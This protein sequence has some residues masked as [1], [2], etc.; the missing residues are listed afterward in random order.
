MKQT[1][2]IGIDVA[3]EV[4]VVCA[5]GNDGQVIM[6]TK[7]PTSVRALTAA[8][9]SVDRPRHVAFEEGCQGEWLH[10]TLYSVCDKLLVCKPL[11]GNKLSGKNKADEA[12]ACNLAKQLRLGALD[13][14]WHG[15][16][17]RR[18]K[19]LQLAG[20]YEA[21]TKDQ[22]RY[23]N[24]AHAV[25]RGEGVKCGN[26]LH[27]GWADKNVLKKLPLEEQKKRV[28]IYDEMI[29]ILNMHRGNVLEA[30]KQEAK[31]TSLYRRVMKAPQIG[32]VFAALLTAIIWVP[33]RFRNNRVFWSYCGLAV[34]V[35]ET[36]QYEI[37]DGSI[38][39]KKRQRTRG[40]SHEYNRT[41]KCIFKRGAILLASGKWKSEFERLQESG[42]SPEN[43]RLT[44]ARKLASITLHLAKTGESYDET[45]VFA[46]Q[47]TVV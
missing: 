13:A 40:R 43:A 42:V 7:V 38:E 33:E 30:L 37:K 19:L 24:R 26:G 5:I 20:T 9:N 4:S 2:Y 32:E 41:L 45:K 46:S 35:H 34:V 31:K 27:E 11:K 44:L 14:V 39:K 15:T 21:L 25:F 29:T 16:E 23:K 1:N 10:R 6:T 18:E 12:D 22:T 36:G 8:I 28:M 47:S 3:K 17:V